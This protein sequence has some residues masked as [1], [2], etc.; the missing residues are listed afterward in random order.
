MSDGEQKKTVRVQR[1]RR[2]SSSGAEGRKRADAPSRKRSSDGGKSAPPPKRP[3]GTSSSQRPTGPRPSGG[4]PLGRGRMSPVMLIGLAVV[5]CICLA[6]YVLLSG[7]GDSEQAV[8][9]PP[10]TESS[11][12]ASA[13]PEKPTSTPRPIVPQSPTTPPEPFNPPSTSTEGQS[14]LVM[15]YQDA[16]DKILEED[17]YVDLNE[18]E[19]VGSSD[20]VHL[21]TQIDRYRAGY[22]GDGDWSSTKRFYITQDNDLQRVNSQHVEDLGEANMSDGQTLVDFV[23][24]AVDTFPADKHVL[25]LSDHGMG[26]PGGWSD[27]APGGRADPSIPLSSALAMSCS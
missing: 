22:R 9:N 21:V 24:W 7:G 10:A 11:S 16:D 17:I 13:L 5:L 14:W 20:R 15:F 1:R 3:T 27:P 26:W 18:A 19:R 23:T 6:G 4:L 8:Y 25:I 12:S 2:T